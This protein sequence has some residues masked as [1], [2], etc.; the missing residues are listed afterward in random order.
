MIVVADTSPLNYL[1]LL[2]HAE[3]LPRL[4]GEVLIPEA[5][6]LE[7]LASEAP[8]N[9]REWISVPPSWLAVIPIGEED[10]AKVT[11]QLDPGERAAIALAEHLRA[12][13]LLMDD[14]IGRSEARRRSFQ[15]TGTLGVLRAAAELQLIDVRDVIERLRATS[16]Y[17]DEELL[18]RVF[19]NWL[20]E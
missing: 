11:K 20:P 19:R 16:F 12:D 17:V 15:V 5:V 18:A 9:V 10:L 14:A 8:Q 13:V 6:A 3:L 4:Y 7:L 1:I 2:G